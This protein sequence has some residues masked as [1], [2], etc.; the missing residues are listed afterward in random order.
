MQTNPFDPIN[1]FGTDSVYGKIGLTKREYFAG[2]ALNG[3]ISGA[4]QNSWH[5]KNFAIGAINLADALIKELNNAP[6][7]KS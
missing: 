4:S 1:P 2:M 6:D 7:Q 3:L 5:E